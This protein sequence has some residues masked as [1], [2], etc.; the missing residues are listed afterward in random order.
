[1]V[2]QEDGDGAKMGQS[3]MCGITAPGTDSLSPLISTPHTSVNS[4]GF[5]DEVQASLTSLLSGDE[6]ALSMDDL[7][8]KLRVVINENMTLKE[9][10]AQNNLALRNQLSLVVQWKQQQDQQQQQFR[11]QVQDIAQQL[12]QA[13]QE[14]VSLKSQITGS[15]VS[16]GP[17]NDM[18]ERYQ[19]LDDTIRMLNKRLETSERSLRTAQEEKDKLQ[20]Q[21]TRLE[22]D[23]TLLK[24]DLTT[25]RG[26]QERLQLER[27]ELL[28][29]VNELRQQ[30]RQA[31]EGAAAQARSHENSPIY[32]EGMGTPLS[33]LETQK[34]RDNLRKEQDTSA[35]LLQELQDTRNQIESME[36][37]VQRA[38]EE[39]SLLRHRCSQM[40]TLN[41]QNSEA[42]AISDGKRG[43]EMDTLEK[44]RLKDEAAMLREE[45][46]TLDAALTAERQKT[47][48]ER[49]A[50][51][52]AH[53]EINRLKKEMTQLR[54]ETDRNTFNDEYYK[55][56]IR[57]INEKLDEGTAK[58]VSYEELL[59]SKNEEIARLKKELGKA[60]ANISE[61]SSEGETIAILRAQVEVY[62]GDFRAER[63]AREAL[64]TDR[65]KLRDDV[66]QLQTRNNQ[67]LDEL[68]A[69]QRRHHAQGRN[70]RATSE[71][72][73]GL[74]AGSTGA[75]GGSTGATG[76]SMGATLAGTSLS[77]EALWEKL[78]N[79][80]DKK[81][82]DKKK[83]EDQ[84][85]ENLF[86]CPKCNKSFTQYKPLEEHV[87]R[88]LDE[89]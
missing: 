70:S 69:Y 43:S 61:M 11:H 45:V 47:Q 48:D 63:E 29:N 22:G 78:S 58:L 7:L 62:Q 85:D 5:T 87:N 75:T 16:S 15:K 82:E 42:S 12:S 79:S 37:D 67:L 55:Q 51:T 27:F 8:G 32:Y 77:Q 59:S 41:V 76:G 49:L 25:I 64:A 65:E 30:L 54:D 14:N 4:N 81:E 72:P 39:A 28:S 44:K 19:E 33:E 21:K 35:T 52:R 71:E 1:M 83:D 88:C 73:S 68:E 34:L 10:V 13:Q 23:S 17:G 46:D 31:R 6:S 53:T 40:Q 74:M 24:C 36:A 86:Y 56:E 26:E 89:D 2:R 18:S 20:V 57:Q 38:Q 80:S 9:T 60:K 66:R 84:L 3:A 50:T